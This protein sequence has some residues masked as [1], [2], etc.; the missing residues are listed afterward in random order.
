[1]YS[2]SSILLIAVSVVGVS[3]DTYEFQQRKSQVD[4]IRFESAF[5]LWSGLDDNTRLAY[6][7]A[8]VGGASA[9]A[10]NFA[11]FKAQKTAVI[12]EKQRAISS[13]E[14]AKEKVRTDTEDKSW[15]ETQKKTTVVISGKSID[16][17][18]SATDSETGYSAEKFRS[19]IAQEAPKLNSIDQGIQAQES[20]IGKQQ[21]KIAASS[22]YSAGA[23]AAAENEASY[24]A[25]LETALQNG[26]T[27]S[28]RYRRLE[29]F[30]STEALT[31]ETINAVFDNPGR[32]IVKSDGKFQVTATNT[33]SRKVT[34]V[35]YS[36]PKYKHFCIIDCKPGDAYSVR[37]QAE[38]QI[39]VT[40]EELRS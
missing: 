16:A 11:A 37:I 20:E 15:V 8:T 31:D 1:M 19:L 32:I 35:S 12:G 7:T 17:A 9:A 18:A 27:P 22:A 36:Q 34:G 13:L 14:E 25:N 29:K 2:I 10:N 3:K 21:R 6:Y 24:I 23:V 30:Q 38:S 5:A 39:Q 40:I 28:L 33:G 4:S 26:F